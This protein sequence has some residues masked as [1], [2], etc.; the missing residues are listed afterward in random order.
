MIN[1]AI[2]KALKKKIGCKTIREAKA[3]TDSVLNQCFQYETDKGRFF[4]KV[5]SSGNI[6]TVAGEAK[7]LEM[8]DETETLI[9]P[10]PHYFG[11]FESQVFLI[12]E[13][14]DLVPHTEKSLE[15]LGQNL[16]L[17]HQ[18]MTHELFGFPIDNVLGRT[19]QL[20]SFDNSWER[21]FTQ[22]RL[23]YQLMINEEK[24]KDAEIRA[25]GEKVLEKVPG[26]FKGLEITPVLLH[27]DLWMGNTAADKS[28]NP[29][30]FDP[31]SYFGHSEVDL[32]I[33]TMFGGFPRSFYEAYHEIIPKEP[34]FEERG[35]LYRLYHTLNHY[36]LF[37]DAYRGECIELMRKI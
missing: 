1:Q 37:G 23:A 28:G 29:V 19:P 26:L 17:L 10:K 21:F 22:N 6:E 3:E 33:T 5:C 36:Y 13:C 32:S 8:I 30:V 20:N 12:M 27:G 15:K 16:A 25:L 18:K 34:G 11:Y 2:Y 31:A 4:V 14:L 9:V 24:Y 35:R 7:A